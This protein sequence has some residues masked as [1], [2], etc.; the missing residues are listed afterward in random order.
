MEPKPRTEL[1]KIGLGYWEYLNLK[2]LRT[3]QNQSSSVRGEEGGAEGGAEGDI[4][5][6]A[7]GGAEDGAD[8]GAEGGIEGGI[9]GGAEG[10]AE[11]GRRQTCNWERNGFLKAAVLPGAGEFWDI[12]FPLR[13]RR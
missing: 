6:G 9:E 3:P 13:Q 12:S 7:E 4:E 10:G 8:G 5:G 11:E 1:A 2:S